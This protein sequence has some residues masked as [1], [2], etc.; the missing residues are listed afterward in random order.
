MKS[1][2]HWCDS[3][4]ARLRPKKP[5]IALLTP[6]P[7]DRSG[8]ALY[9]SECLSG[10]AKLATVDVFT[11]AKG[12][13]P[14]PD[15]R[16]FAPISYYPFISGQ[17][18]QVVSV[19]GSSAFHKKIFDLLRRYG[20]P[21]IAHDTRMAPYYA[22]EHELTG[23]AEMGQRVLGRPVTVTEAQEWLSIPA[24]M[25]SMFMHEIMDSGDPVITH[26]RIANEL[27]VKEYDKQAAYVPFAVMTSFGEEELEA[28]SRIAARK[29][30]NLPDDRVVIVSMGIVHP[31][32]GIF[33]ILWTIEQLLAWDVPAELYLVGSID[34]F[35][36]PQIDELERRLGINEHVHLMEGDWIPDDVYRDFILAAD[37]AIQ[38]RTYGFGVLSAGVQECISAGL[39][40]VVNVN[41]ADSMESPGYMLRVPDNLSPVL[42][43]EQL[44]LAYEEG[45][46][47]Q[48]R[49]RRERSEYVE[50]HTF[51]NY[52]KEL[53][54]AI[55]LAH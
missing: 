26:S 33:E 18:D 16:Q 29:R 36:C 14:H 40:A 8:V 9:S 12:F 7:P 11:D 27:L 10:L 47:N 1:Y 5:C 48:P 45:V 55:G 52:A 6:Y 2:R 30:L 38:I 24:R 42:M 43:A 37:F 13:V 28:D 41:L 15:V 51:D 49:L 3:K 21:C 32:K 23:L 4:P 39:P 31:V 17:Y 46:H 22:W 25:P 34:P 20:G 54:A 50:L 53:M 19:M 35:F 44:L